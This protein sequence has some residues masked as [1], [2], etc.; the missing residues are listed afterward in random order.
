MRAGSTSISSAAFSSCPTAKQAESLSSYPPPDWRS[1]PVFEAFTQT[2]PA[3]Q[4]HR[5]AF[6]AARADETVR[7]AALEQ[8]RDAA[9]FVRKR[10]LKLGK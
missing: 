8:E 3:F 1:L 10:L 5:S 6:A 9:R 7:P 4:R 2:R